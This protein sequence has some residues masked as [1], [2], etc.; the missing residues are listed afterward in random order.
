MSRD[1]KKKVLFVIGM[2]QKLERFI[3]EET[4]VNLENTIILQTYQPVVSHP[5]DDLMRDIIIAVYQDNV[6]E[7]IV[8]STNDD[9]KNT[10]DILNKIDK[11]KEL[12]NKIQTLDYLFKNCM[13]EFPDGSVS[14]WLEEGK[15]L[16]DG[17]QKTVN[18]IRNHPLLPSQVKVK[19]LYID[20]ENE[21]VS[22]IAGVN[23]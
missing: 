20:L 17:V 14:G 11:N 18:I 6:E 9:Q 7:I 3:K 16:T 21:K 8:V 10:G 2:E 5:F 19:E 15:T 23:Y 1:E 12:Q 13:P 22:E 4:N